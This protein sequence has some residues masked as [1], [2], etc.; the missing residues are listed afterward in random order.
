MESASANLVEGAS[1]SNKRTLKKS[2]R[3][4]LSSINVYKSYWTLREKKAI[5]AGLKQFGGADQ[6][7][8][9]ELVKTKTSAEVKA[10]ISS[11]QR[12]ITVNSTYVRAPIEMWIDKAQKNLS[13]KCDFSVG[14]AEVLSDCS[15]RGYSE[16]YNFLIHLVKCEP[17]PEL[18]KSSASILHALL[19]DLATLVRSLD[20]DELKKC[21]EEWED[22]VATTS[23][24]NGELKGDDIFNLYD[25]FATMDRE[26]VASFNP[27]KIPSTILRNIFLEARGNMLDMLEMMKK[28]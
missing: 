7:K 18:S 2:R 1:V 24:D 19:H 17:P 11:R 28:K 14:L 9:A 6:D 20:L 13:Q 25:Q 12:R 22:S 21:V 10:F 8:L 23:A 27:L 16:I 26:S 3:S 15:Q 4:S 5:L